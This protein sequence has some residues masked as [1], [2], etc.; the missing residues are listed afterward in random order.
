LK[1]PNPSYDLKIQQRGSELILSFS[2]PQ[3]TIGGLPLPELYGVEYWELLKPVP[4]WASAEEEGETEAVIEEGAEAASADSDE[5]GLEPGSSK[6]ASEEPSEEPVDRDKSEGDDVGEEAEVGD[7]KETAEGEDEDEEDEKADEAEPTPVAPQPTKEQLVAVEPLEF[8]AAALLRLTLEG[9][10]LQSSI[11]GDRI[12]MRFPLGEEPPQET[13]HIFGVKTLVS[14]R[15]ASPL[16]NLATLVRRVPPPPPKGF[17]AEAQAGGILITWENELAKIE[18]EAE[19]AAATSGTPATPATPPPLPPPFGE[20]IEED[21]LRGFHIYRRLAR[22]RAYGERLGAVGPTMDQYLDRTAQYGS[23]YIYSITGVMET[24]PLVESGL[25]GEREINYQDRFAPPPPR[26]LIALAEAGRVRLLWDASLASDLAGYIVFRR[27]G[28]GDFRREWHHLRVPCSRGRSRRQPGRDGHHGDR[29]R[30]MIP[31]YRLSAGGNDFLALVEPESVPSGEAVRGLC[32][33]GL[34][35]GADG[36]FVL[37]PTAA[38]AQMEY[39]NADGEGA[40]LCLN[41]V[42]CAAHLAF[43]LSWSKNHLEV[44]TGAGAI[45][46][47]LDGEGGV[48]LAVP[49]PRGEPEHVDIPIDDQVHSGFRLRIGVPYFVLPWTETLAHAPVGTLGERL[50]HAQEL[51]PPGANVDFIRFI[52]RDR[53][54]MRVFERGVEA[55]TLASGTGALAAIAVGIHLGETDLPAEVLTLGGHIFKVEGEVE[56]NHP[57]R[58][59]LAGDSRLLAEGKYH[60]IAETRSLPP[61]WSS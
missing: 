7:A 54:E 53:I 43:S 4:E 22:D 29:A 28:D 40:A 38:G 12:V 26:N 24:R 13:A 50:R 5:P 42:R 36:L 19:P 27:R 15:I 30:P 3:T 25:A 6:E 23:R 44:L 17:S 46:A 61:D 20:A 37:R 9:P 16:S 45:E 33:R 60:E 32:A 55:E 2:Y 21:G 14:P 51:G 47:T 59:S 31:F 39:F 10:E 57:V 49:T 8:V 52:A 35:L 58:W 1:N 34:S 18:L 56:D 11:V 48:S 41:G